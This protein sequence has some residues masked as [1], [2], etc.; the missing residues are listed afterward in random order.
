MLKRFEVSEN[1][2]FFQCF[3]R[4]KKKKKVSI[5]LKELYF[6]EDHVFPK[7]EWMEELSHSDLGMRLG[8]LA[9]TGKWFIVS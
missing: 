2:S 6:S 8:D 7:G 9:G 3:G 1:L 5:C 4:K